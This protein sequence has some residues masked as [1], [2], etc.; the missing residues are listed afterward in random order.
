MI[1]N[2]EL[3]PSMVTIQLVSVPVFLIGEV[4]IMLI[5]FGGCAVAGRREQYLHELFSQFFSS[6]V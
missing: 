4:R 3:Q 1:P 6:N 2:A 5:C